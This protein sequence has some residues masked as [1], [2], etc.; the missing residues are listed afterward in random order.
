MSG[1]KLKKMLDLWSDGKGV[2]ALEVLFVLLY[3][4]APAEYLQRYMH[5][6]YVN[7]LSAGSHLVI[8]S[9][10]CV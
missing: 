5:L 3:R 6:V 4:L 1:K 8:T 7:T 9:G 2:L 10:S